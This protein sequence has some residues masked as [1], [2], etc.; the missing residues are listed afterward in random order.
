MTDELAAGVQGHLGR[1]TLNRPK[2]LNALTLDM[3]R[4][5]RT[6]LDAWGSDPRVAA[7]AIAGAGERG[8]CAGGD[9]RAIYESRQKGDSLAHIFWRE[10]YALNALIAGYP[11]P[12]VAV[13]DGL[14]MGG[15]VGI[16]AHAAHRVVTERTRLAMPEVGIGFMPDVGGTWLLSR[17]PGETG[18]LMALT[19]Q[20]VG[21]ADAIFA[22]LADRF[23]P[24]DRLPDLL[25]D[26]ESEA[27]DA[28]LAR[29]SSDAGQSSLGR[30]RPEIDR[31]LGFDTVEEIRAALQGSRADWARQALAAI[32]GKSPTALKLALAALRRARS[33]PD[34]RACL[35]MEYRVVC[36]LFAGHD[37]IEG[38]RAAVIDKDRSP[39]WRPARLEEVSAA[40]VESYF[41]PLHEDETKLGD[42][43]TDR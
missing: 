8:L 17:A 30:L 20:P 6:A 2:A 39:R 5:M 35:D 25:A 32:E 14:V 15:G 34:L 10:E 38:I 24:S 7:V 21:A 28:V 16:S 40:A 29:H 37:F 19:G 43:G 23:V 26:L 18:T 9:L 22:R 1:I 13:M 36:R 42:T 27:V 41:A 11:K 4:A 12:I 31:A 33:L 3:I